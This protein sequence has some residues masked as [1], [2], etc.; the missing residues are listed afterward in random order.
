[1][2]LWRRNAP[3]EVPAVFH[4]AFRA[5]DGSEAVV[6]VN[7]TDREQAGTL[8]WGGRETSLTLSPWEL[9]LIGK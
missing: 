7:I 2:N 8:A 6:M 1:M 5:P 3:R 4:N 9:R